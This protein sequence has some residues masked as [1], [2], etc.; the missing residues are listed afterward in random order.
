LH[1]ST[2]TAR[3]L[4]RYSYGHIEVLTAARRVWLNQRAA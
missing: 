1:T 3:L 4:I 2:A